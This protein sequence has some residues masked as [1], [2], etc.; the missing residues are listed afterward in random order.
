MIDIKSVQFTDIK[1]S[2]FE[3]KVKCLHFGWV[4]DMPRATC[5]AED[6]IEAKKN[7]EFNIFRKAHKLGMF[8]CR[9]VDAKKFNCLDVFARIMA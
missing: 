9:F 1:S 2:K 5:R 4:L 3:Q 6:E 7:S 8:F